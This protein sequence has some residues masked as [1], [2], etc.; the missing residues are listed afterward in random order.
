MIQAVD[1]LQ[2]FHEEFEERSRSQSCGTVTDSTQEL[3]QL[4]GATLL[5]HA[6]DSSSTIQLSSA[7]GTSTDLICGRG[8]DGSFSFVSSN[9]KG[10]A[11]YLRIL[12]RKNGKIVTDM[13][14]TGGNWTKFAVTES[15]AGDLVVKG[16]ASG[17][18]LSVTKKG[19]FTA[20]DAEQ[21][22]RVG[23]AAQQVAWEEEAMREAI[24]ASRGTREERGER[25]GWGRQQKVAAKAEPEHELAIS[26]TSHKLE[27]VQL[28]GRIIQLMNQKLQSLEQKNS[29]CQQDVNSVNSQFMQLSKQLKSHQ[30]MLLQ[31]EAHNAALAEKVASLERVGGSTIG[32]L[33]REVKQLLKKQE[34]QTAAAACLNQKS[35]AWCQATS[36]C[37]DLESLAFES[38]EKCSGAGWT[39]A[40]TDKYRF[41]PNQRVDTRGRS[42]EGIY[43]LQFWAV[44]L[45][46][47]AITVL[48][49]YQNE[50][51]RRERIQTARATLLPEPPA[52][53]V[54]L[55]QGA[56]V[57][58]QGDSTVVNAVS[59]P[60]A[61]VIANISESD[62]VSKGSADS[63]LQKTALIAED[64]VSDLLRSIR[65]GSSVHRL[66]LMGF[67][68]A[69]AIE[70]ALLVAGGDL[71]AAAVAL[72]ELGPDS[73]AEPEPKAV[74]EDEWDSLLDELQ[75]MGFD[76]NAA[77]KQVLQASSGNLKGAVQKLVQEEREKAN[78]QVSSE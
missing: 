30:K 74:W 22:L 23:S 55:P 35:N 12:R 8:K 20:H 54:P 31:Q 68:P 58:A 61:A 9:S 66:Q 6:V 46:G 3:A 70:R 53:A 64:Q 75:E 26:A 14:G 42:Q 36:R 50:K 72:V 7:K 73:K 38:P 69:D 41:K 39:F 2:S 40:Q 4:S 52:G 5:S 16:L 19:Q 13:K 71:S 51:G 15:A 67:G 49:I 77:N 45:L 65:S 76:D 62:R 1:N 59:L 25:E 78:V 57:N 37:R 47:L 28:M 48:V 21:G 33:Q 27:S 17:M 24:T 63:T 32:A 43:H 34:D 18:W 44:V 60:Q 10:K 29:Q 56:V 11:R